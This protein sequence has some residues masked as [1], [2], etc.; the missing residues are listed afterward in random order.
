MNLSRPFE[1]LEQHAFQPLQHAAY[2]KGLLRPF[3]G[4]GELEAWANDCFGLRDDLVSLAQRRVLPQAN[5]RPLNLLP[6][7]LAQQS[8]GAGTTF[9][10]WRN[11]DRSAMGVALWEA[12]IASPD[13]PSSLIPELL[14]L[15]EQRIVLN[16][17]ISLL[18]T[19]ARQ[20][21]DCAGKM[22]RAH[23]AA[24][25]RAGLRQQSDPL[26]RGATL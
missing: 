26:P 20:A 8:T 22:Q 5:R 10:R 17:Q 12:M 3:K 2:L 19:I 7:Q 6:A 9:L 15:E 16:M 11:P 21:Q 18:H 13:T 25:R 23:D 24:A 14:M 4:K 1:P